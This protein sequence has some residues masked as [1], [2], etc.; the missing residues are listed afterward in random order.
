[1]R[2]YSSWEREK[3]RRLQAHGYAVEVLYPGRE[4]GIS[5]TRVRELIRSGAAWDR[6]VTAVSAR[7]IR[8]V[9]AAKP[10]RFE[11]R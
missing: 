2:V 9:L 10:G 3:V 4:K 11:R 7:I 6:L 1:M 8:E 5:G